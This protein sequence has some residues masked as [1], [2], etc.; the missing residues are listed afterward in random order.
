VGEVPCERLIRADV[1]AKR[2]G[3]HVET[4]YRWMRAGHVAYVQ[5][6]RR[7][8]CVRESELQRLLADRRET[9]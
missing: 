8:K 5:P 1:A 6:G 9:A 3:V 7:R 2:L 4:L